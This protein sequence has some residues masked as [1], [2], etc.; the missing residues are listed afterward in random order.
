MNVE[1][2]FTLKLAYESSESVNGLGHAKR[3]GHFISILFAF[4]TI[5]LLQDGIPRDGYHVI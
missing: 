2:T 5:S 3:G 4:P 1:R